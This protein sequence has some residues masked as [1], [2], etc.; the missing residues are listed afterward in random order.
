M[1]IN[2][3]GYEINSKSLV[4]MD[5]DSHRILLEKNGNEK[6]LIASTTKVMT[7]IISLEYGKLDEIVLVGDEVLKAYG[8]NIYITKGES[9]LYL[10]LIYGLMLRSGNDASLVLSSHTFKSYDDF[11]K[12][13]NIK[14]K[15][16]GMNDTIF[17]N[18]SGLD[19]DNQNI[20]TA[21]DMALLMAYASKNKKFLEIASTKNY[22]CYSD[23]KIYVWKN[24][25]EL[26]FN[27]DVT[28]CKTGYTPKAGRILATSASND[29]L[30]LIMIGFGNSYDYEMQK[31]IYEEY[32]KKYKNYKLIDKDS[33]NIKY[34]GKTGYVKNSFSYPLRDD[35]IDKVVTK[36]EL[37]KKITNNELGSIYVYFDDSF[38]HKEIIYAKERTNLL[39][40]L[41][42]LFKG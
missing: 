29:D 13:M 17:T 27:Y 2:V 24:R 9:I 21:H 12:M 37:N 1:P 3:L 18:P 23:Q 38:L 26:L 41:F 34:L 25:C 16:L 6:R 19:D 8:S 40:K 30:N 35:E 42:R 31:G 22:T 4:L 15:E 28:S 7:A 32:F 11:I 5:R 39:L 33:F 10:D 20:S 14:A 36:V